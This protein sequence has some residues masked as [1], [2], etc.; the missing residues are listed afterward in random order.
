[1]NLEE[2]KEALV[3]IAIYKDPDPCTGR[4]VWPVH[5]P[6]STRLAHFLDALPL[7]YGNR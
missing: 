7:D 2:F 4:W 6:L 5:T 1:M 3:T